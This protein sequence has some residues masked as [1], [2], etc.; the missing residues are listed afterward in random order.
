MSDLEF[1]VINYLTEKKG[2]KIGREFEYQTAVGGGRTKY[3]G[4][5]VDFLIRPFLILQP[6]GQRWHLQQPRDRARLRLEGILLAGRGYTVVYLWE[7]D[8]LSRPDLT[9]ENALLGRSMNTF[10]NDL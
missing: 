6:Q 1:L 7:D 2:Y 4:F 3:G 9:I 10:R 5:I 8:L